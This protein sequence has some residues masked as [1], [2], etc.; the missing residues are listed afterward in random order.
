MR[1]RF[2]IFW[3]YFVRLSLRKLWNIITAE[4]G[5]LLSLISRQPITGK[6]PTSITVELTNKCNFR[7]PHCY[8]GG[9]FG[10]REQG[11]MNREVFRRIVDQAAGKAHRLL[12]YFQGESLLHP[13][14]IDFIRYANKKHLHTY[15]STNGSLLA[16]ELSKQ[17]IAS[18][19]DVLV[20]SYDGK[21]Q[22]TYGKYR[23]NGNLEALDRAIEIFHHE[24]L[25]SGS[26]KPLV[27]LQCIVMKSN[28]HEISEIRRLQKS[29]SIDRVQLKTLQLLDFNKTNQWLPS[30]ASYNRYDT[31][32]K[33]AKNRVC[34]QLWR[35]MVILW[36]G[37]VVACCN[38][39]NGDFAWGS[40]T[41]NSIAGIWKC[42][43]ANEFRKNVLSG[44]F[45]EICGNCFYS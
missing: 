14:L 8:T 18:G 39:K 10:D 26:N 34:K 36:D 15:L 38:D 35:S 9:S 33:K 25:E 11:M 42:A 19:L 4:F 22:E 7:C 31:D 32:E 12:L 3:S 41:L 44:S 2:R 5:W 28:E 16:E 23:I 1:G 13:E 45:P 29:E 27:I 30:D 6:Y 20:I 17:I 37:Q 24:K 43:T 21:S 40:I